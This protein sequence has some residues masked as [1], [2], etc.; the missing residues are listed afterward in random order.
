M[1]VAI[2]GPQTIK[3]DAKSVDAVH[4]K[5]AVVNSQRASLRRPPLTLA[6]AAR[7][8]MVHIENLPDSVFLEVGT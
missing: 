4:N 1:Q 2:Y 5:L 3:V 6:A 7:I 8:A